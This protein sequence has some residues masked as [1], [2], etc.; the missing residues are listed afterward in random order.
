MIPVSKEQ[1]YRQPPPNDKF[2]R[3]LSY[4]EKAFNKLSLPW[5]LAFGSALMYHRSNNFISD[6][7][8]IGIFYNDLNATCLSLEKLLPILRKF[9]FRLLF[10]YD[11]PN[12]GQG[13]SFQNTRFL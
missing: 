8:A 3:C 13:W 4:A 7:I 6:D 5:F 11:Q 1:T 2:T 12:H 10:T 9:R